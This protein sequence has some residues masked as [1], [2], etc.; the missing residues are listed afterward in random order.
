MSKK[1]F[2]KT[3]DYINHLAIVIAILLIIIS[4]F[5]YV[6]EINSQEF[7]NFLK[8]INNKTI[9]GSFSKS[10]FFFTSFTTLIFFV[11]SRITKEKK[12]Q[13]ILLDFA[14]NIVILIITTTFLIILSPTVLNFILEN[15][16]GLIIS[17]IYAIY[18]AFIIVR[19]TLLFSMHFLKRLIG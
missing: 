18:L 11:L 1:L 12:Y 17:L 4:A 5:F 16:F 8:K 15:L 6:G 3:E 2:K 19:S 10:F 14:R 9:L 7:I 13:K